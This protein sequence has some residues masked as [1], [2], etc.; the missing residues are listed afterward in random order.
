MIEQKCRSV[1]TESILLA[2]ILIL[3][4]LLRLYNLSAKSLWID[5]I[6]EV[7]VASENIPLLLTGVASHLSPPLDYIILHFLLILGK[8]DF[9]V[10][11]PSA[12]FGV[13]SIAA[14]YLLGAELYSKK[15]GLISA[16]LIA[17]S[18]YCIW[19]SQEARMYSL[20]LF[21]SILSIY[22]FFRWLKTDSTVLWAAYLILTT[23][24]LYTHYFA[25]FIIVV[26]T[27][28]IIFILFGRKIKGVNTLFRGGLIPKFISSLVLMFIIFLPWLNVFLS[29][30][31][32][33]NRVL[34]YGLPADARF[35]Y[36]IS[37]L[38]IGA[39]NQYWGMAAIAIFC[40]TAFGILYSLNDHTD[41]TILLLFWAVLPIMATF[42]LSYLRGPMT[43]DRNMIFIIPAFI[44]L[45]AKGISDLDILCSKSISDIIKQIGVV[46][47][48]TVIV[49]VLMI[50]ALLTVPAIERG[51]AQEKED[52][53]GLS[54]YLTRQVG[55]TDLI[56]IF[57]DSAE[58]LKYYYKGSA[59]IISLPQRL[60]DLKNDV[61]LNKTYANRRIWIVGT[62]HSGLDSETKLWLD[63]NCRLER[64]GLTNGRG[65][66][67]NNCEINARDGILDLKCDSQTADF[68]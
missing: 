3:G 58:H 52:W 26:Q 40:I 1:R 13:G 29:Q 32:D 62:P 42:T 60:D 17:I 44:I 30:T 27:V 16:F 43:T 5:E 59:E 14:V 20:F 57:R 6:G 49:M 21:L 41:R 37:G 56:V 7:I 8:S 55:N 25:F 23:L 66:V 2:G 12:L 9:I 64:R 46:P 47:P 36:T 61:I 33:L 63:T 34:W 39:F 22:F 50:I 28:F 65:N 24:A 19:Y 18:P 67:Y 53:Q 48:G 15:V 68:C 51:Y 4:L 45:F 31:G 54:D 11:L 38:V 10:R 35:F